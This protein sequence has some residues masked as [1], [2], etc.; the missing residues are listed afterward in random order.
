MDN[1]AV[2]VD[3]S[4]ATFDSLIPTR[5]AGRRVASTIAEGVSKRAQKQA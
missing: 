3:E 2:A 5:L 1:A 4:L